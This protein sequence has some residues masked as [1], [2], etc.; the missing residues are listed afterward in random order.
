MEMVTAYAS[1][2]NGG[3]RVRAHGD[4]EDQ[5]PARLRGQ[6]R[7][8][9]AALPRQ[10][11]WIFSDGVAAKATEILQQNLSSGTGGRAQPLH[12]AVP[13]RRQNW[14]RRRQPDAWFAGF[15]PRMSSSVWVGYP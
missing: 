5:V 4:H 1:I 2:A 11:P 10:L 3:L 9:A 8:A 7:L 13:R 12:V 14:H 6:G 15:T